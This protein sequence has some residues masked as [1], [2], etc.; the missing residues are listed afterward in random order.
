LLFNL[1]FDQGHYLFFDFNLVYSD[2]FY[3]IIFSLDKI[4]GIILWEFSGAF[5][6]M[7]V[8]FKSILN[9]LKV[10]VPYSYW[11]W[12]HVLDWGFVS[13]Y[14][15]NL[16][17]SRANLLQTKWKVLSIGTPLEWKSNHVYKC[18][19]SKICTPKKGK[20]V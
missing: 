19:T 13:A 12:N 5:P 7:L 8:R 9:T 1:R 3:Y 11:W 2:F 6:I 4:I 16:C 18:S 10:K 20:L 17:T 15:E 14:S